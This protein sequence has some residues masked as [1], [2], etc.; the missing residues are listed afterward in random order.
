MYVIHSE[1]TRKSESALTQVTRL[2][3]QARVGDGGKMLARAVGGST[4]ASAIIVR[5]AAA[6][7]CQMWTTEGGIIVD[8]FIQGADA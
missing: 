4:L 8:A 5:G 1:T 6:K 3:G 7:N 2:G